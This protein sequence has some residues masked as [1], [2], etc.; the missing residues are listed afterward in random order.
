[1]SK[2]ALKIKKGNLETPQIGDSYMIGGDDGTREKFVGG[3]RRIGREA[4]CDD[5]GD[6]IGEKHFGHDDG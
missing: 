1:M 5:N 3:D 4:V 2:C 6:D